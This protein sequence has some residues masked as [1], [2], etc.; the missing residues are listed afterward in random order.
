MINKL[1]IFLMFV[2]FVSSNVAFAQNKK[3]VS[4]TVTGED[5]IPLV[6]V[7][8]IEK[9]TSNGTSTDF[10]GN[11]NVVVSNSSSVLVFSSLGF[12]E[13][14]IVV[15]E[16][17]NIDVVLIGSDELLGEV[18]VTAL[19]IK[20]TTKA[21]GY[22]LTEVGGDELSTIK[23][24]NAVNSLQGKIAGVNVTQNSTGAAGSSRVII[25][26]SST[27]TGDNQPL[28]VID[29]IPISNVNNGSAGLWGGSDGGDGISS[30]NPD[31]IESVSVLKG[32]AAS[33]LYGSRAAGGV[34]IVTTKSGK[35]QKG[36]GVEVSSSVTFDQV[37]TS[38]QDFQ[39]EYGQGRRGAKPVNQ[40]EALDVGLSSWGERL[41][42]SSV[43]QWDG[44]SRPYS[45]VGNNQEHFYRTGTTFINSV[46]LTNGGEDF[47][48]RFSASDLTNEDIT[49]N[50]GLNRKTF[51]LNSGAVM[52]DK[53]TTQVNVKYILEEVNNRPRLSDA[54]GNGNFTVANLAPNV[55]VRFMNPGA[56]DDLTE[57]QYSS[58]SFSQNPYFAAYN[59]RNE[60]TKNRVIASTSLRYDVFDWLYVSGRAGI[61]HY[62]IRRTAVEPF[63]TAYKPL[64]GIEERE[65]RYSQID[66]DLIL[67]VEKDITD[68]F[69]TN[70]F[71]G[72]NGN[73]VSQ[74]TKIL[75][76]NDFIV[77]G[78][79]QFGNTVNQSAENN[80]S[81][82]GN[83]KRKIGSLYGSVEFSY[84][85]FAYLT[86]T[87]RNDWFSTLSF[88]G[89][90]TSNNDF[91]P[92]VNA[93][94]ILSQMFE[95]PE[96][97][98][99]LKLRGGYSEVAGGAQ[100]PY[101]LALTYQIFGQG[102]LGQPLGSINGD[103]VPNA[104]L[105]AFSKSESEIGID[106]RFFNSRLSFDVAYYSNETTNDIVPVGTSVFSGYNTAL[107]NIG[108][109]ENKGIEFLISG[110]PVKTENFSWTTSVNGAH[111][112]GKVVATNEEGGEIS[113]GEPRSRNV[114]IKQIVGEPYG[115]IFGVPYVRDDNGNIV[116]EI[117]GDGVPLAQRGER[118]ILGEGVPPLTLGFTNTI[119]YK[120]VTLNFLIDGKFGGQI[121]SGT[122]TVTYGNGL[123]KGTLAGRENGL[124]VTGVNAETGEQFTTTVAPEDLQTYYGRISGIAE[125]F[126]EDSDYIKFRQLSLGYTFPNSI[127]DKTFLDSASISLIA[128]NLFYL[129]R[130]VDN[131]DPES[132]YNVGNA[133]GLEYFGLPST[134]SYGL[135]VNLKF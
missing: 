15:N 28:Y 17:T 115:V 2:L 64:G 8:V 22:S 113:L 92:S 79:E 121:F 81:G 47:N 118:K 119:T 104:N 80:F 96:A 83:G 69:A 132:A 77:P 4:G 32:G 72:A 49:P 107:A 51:S 133:Q 60:D 19:G 131:I 56:N 114:E 129:M 75:R 86:F 14:E 44:V 89:K 68:K 112:T 66:A 31:D 39:T 135:N 98:D 13:K 65:I 90:N 35:E 70:V 42:G 85:D 46:A 45:Y 120:N 124:T 9:G 53:L 109:V 99:F 100:D 76:G 128:S 59:F 111:N 33:A 16:K 61:D 95:L 24:P 67:G 21:L 12:E 36:F 122:N 105:V 130:T 7:N 25:R 40:E 29:G 87:G 55:D 58:N 1:L 126:V 41:D 106:A 101:Q 134:R 82:N 43:I 34:I 71:I 116:Y 52:A 102:H 38:L 62:T 127:L 91:Y 5:G 108:I 110:T 84:D 27:L 97:I 30:I 54:P 23:L 11:Y 125:E 74:E 50:S 26:G 3:T 93:S 37:D 78:L 73:S 20:K 48:Y 63:G 123:H 6:G 94:L 103:R 88:P 57:R 18:V 10:D 117:D